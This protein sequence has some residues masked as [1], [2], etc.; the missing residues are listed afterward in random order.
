MK[1]ELASPPFRGLGEGVQDGENH[2]GPGGGNKLG[3]CED[4][5][6]CCEVGTL[7]VESRGRPGPAGPVGLCQDLGFYCKGSA[8]ALKSFKQRSDMIR[9]TFLKYPSGR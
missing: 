3:S 9:F 5:K 4:Q 7:A 1:A 2:V 6:G 8:K